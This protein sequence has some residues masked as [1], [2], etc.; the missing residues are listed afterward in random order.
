VATKYGNL[1]ESLLPESTDF[2]AIGLFEQAAS[3]E[4]TQFDS[5]AEP[6]VLKHVIAK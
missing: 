1:A 2:A 4:L 5:I 6:L 3:I